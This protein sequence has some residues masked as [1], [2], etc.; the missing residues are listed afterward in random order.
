MEEIQGAIF[1]V[2]YKVCLESVLY[3]T[4]VHILDT[5]M[6][7][8]SFWRVAMLMPLLPKK[9]TSRQC[10]EWWRHGSLKMMS[11]R[12]RRFPEVVQVSCLATSTLLRHIRSSGMGS[13]MSESEKHYQRS[14]G[15]WCFP[16]VGM[17]WVRFHIHSHFRFSAPSI[18]CFLAR[19][20]FC[21]VISWRHSQSPIY[22]FICK[23]CA[24]VQR[25]WL[26]GRRAGVETMVLSLLH[27][28]SSFKVFREP[29]LVQ[30]ALFLCNV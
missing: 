13:W 10:D 16:Y 28:A 18:H 12:W 27:V 5:S 7:Q 24:P 14:V 9:S 20:S 6:W 22:S 23:L 17:G 1:S 26:A 3:W 30:P 21:L 25:S 2:G 29:G 8:M 15:N 19:G 11:S 4:Y